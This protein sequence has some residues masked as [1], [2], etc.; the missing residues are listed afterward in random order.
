MS[1]PRSILLP[2]YMLNVPL[3]TQLCN[4]MDE[5]LYDT[6]W[7]TGQL[8]TIRDPYA[9]GPLIQQAIADGTMYDTSSAEYQ[10]DMQILL[11]QLSFNGMPLSTPSF[12]TSPQALLLF[13]NCGEYWFS[14]GT[15]KLIDFLNFTLS[16][17][18]RMES[19]WTNDY[20]HFEFESTV[21]ASPST[22]PPI[23]T[24]GGSW[25]PTTHVG[26]DLGTAPTFANVQIQDFVTFF[27]DFFN[28]N[29]VLYAVNSGVN[30]TLGGP[31]LSMNLYVEEE[32]FVSG[33]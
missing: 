17:T 20:R 28:Y 2:P 23:T 33:S 21:L 1:N 27:N 6:D 30:I 22:Y 9:I 11:K 16:A 18:L 29:L 24:A 13:R 7:A 25:Y 14:K 10:Q 31:L 32:F 26:I 15:G 8:R 5:L 3:W 4:A 12:I 19:M